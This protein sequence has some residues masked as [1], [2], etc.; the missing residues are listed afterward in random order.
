MTPAQRSFYDEGW[1]LGYT[2]AFVG[3]DWKTMP[4][5]WQQGFRTAIM[6]GL[7]NPGARHQFAAA[8]TFAA[9]VQRH[10]WIAV[11]Q[12]TLNHLAD[13]PRPAWATP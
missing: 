13:G 11:E 4:E 10:S 2:G 1:F 5:P 6:D 9:I 7:A 12:A 3:P 8:A